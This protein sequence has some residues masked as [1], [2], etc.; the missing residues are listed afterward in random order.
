MRKVMEEVEFEGELADFFEYLNTDQRFY[1]DDKEELLSGYRA[2]R[3]D[4][5]KKSLNI[6]NAMPAADFE[7]RPVE[8][9]R[10]QSAA[11]GSYMS[12]AP[13]GSRP[14]VFYVNTY[15]MSARPM[16]AMESLYL[17]EAVP[18]HH[19]QISIQRELDE[20][21]RFRRFGGYT[22]FSE[23]WGLYAES[24][25]KELGVYEDPYQYF[26]ALAAE[27]FRSIRLVVDTGLH[28][29]GW[30]RQQVLDYMYAN[31]AIKEAR[32]VSE[33]ERY[34]A[35]PGQALAYKIG[36]LKIAELRQNAEQALGED[37]DVK[38]FHAQILEDGALPLD[39]LETKI[40]R[41]VGDQRQRVAASE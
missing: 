30:T 33:T 17:H 3:E 10:E 28:A 2:L 6:F 26:G 21:P 35:I 14:G 41:W 8:P 22:A 32:A 31:T 40:E 11:G 12:A 7:I 16:W 24:L 34:I 15:D 23:G 9:F 37:F 1:Y 39:V 25:G 20:L 38:A 19:F 36:Q 5:E 27:L 4:V 29:K 18:G 13:D